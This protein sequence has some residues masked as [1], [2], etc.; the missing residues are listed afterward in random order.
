MEVLTLSFPDLP[1]ACVGIDSRLDPDPRGLAFFFFRLRDGRPQV[2]A[3]AALVW[4][5]RGLDVHLLDRVL[6]HGAPHERGESRR[7]G[8]ARPVCCG[9][10]AAEQS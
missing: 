6:L 2:V 9:T 10:W 1:A 8:W 7:G 4:F 5:V 3:F